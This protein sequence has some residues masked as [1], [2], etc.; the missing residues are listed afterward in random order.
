MSLKELLSV[1][2]VSFDLK[3]TNKEAVIEELIEILNK[4]GKLKDK[5]K[6]KEAVIKRE[7]DYSTGIGMGVAIPHGK[8]SSVQEPALT[9]GISR[10]GIDFESMDDEKAH[11]FFLIAVPENSDNLHLQVLSQISRRLMHTEVR[12]RLFKA[13]NYQEV[14]EAFED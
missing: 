14:L 7:K 9:F 12:E 3:S 13:Q 11:I 4:D 10:E 5:D 2:R 1:N 6:F 8:D